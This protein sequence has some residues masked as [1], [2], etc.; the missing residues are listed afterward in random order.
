MLPIVH[1]GGGN[2]KTKFL[3]TIRGCLGPDYTT[4]VVM[5]TLIVTKGEQHPTDLAD[6]RGK[7]LAVAVETEEGRYP[8]VPLGN[9]P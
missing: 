3:E 2:G 6:L 1:G 9:R 7:R 8:Q 5:E 4:N